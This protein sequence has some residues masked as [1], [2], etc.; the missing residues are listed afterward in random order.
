VSNEKALVSRGARCVRDLTFA[1]LLLAL[2]MR[3]SGFGAGEIRVIVITGFYSCDRW[4]EPQDYFPIESLAYFNISLMNLGSDLSNISICL[5]VLDD[6]GVPVGLDQYSASVPP[7]VHTHYLMSVFIPKWARVGFAIAYVS[8]FEA[9]RIVDDAALEFYIGPADL[10][11]PT[12]HLLFPENTTYRTESV[13][14]TFVVDERAFWTGYSLDNG[15]NVSIRSNTTL[16]GLL[17]GYYSVRVY[18]NDSSGNAGA[19][20]MVGFT[21]AVVHNVAV[22]GLDCSSTD[23]YV[24]EIVNI[25]V[26]AQNKGTVTETFTVT[27]YA[28]TTIIDGKWVTLPSGDSTV[29]T[30][31]WNASTFTRGNYR[32][33]AHAPPIQGETNTTDNIVFGDSYVCV[34]L[35]GDVDRDFDVDMS[36]IIM[37]S[38]AYG[39][40]EGDP[41]FLANCD[42]DRDGDIDIYDI[43]IAA[44]NY[45]KS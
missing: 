33:S 21:V 28:N 4:G 15:Q 27:A 13:P 1:L 2:F 29:I 22:L 7:G 43:I 36:D 17:N 34:T 20:E 12:I 10:V 24:D 19:S 40:E 16:T 32:I 39:T 5:S 44:G 30:F 37:M 45:G 26:S 3:S 23:V 18:G 41:R 35:R 9:G 42:T 8:V 25:I 14:L 38:G 11:P 31:T 6:S